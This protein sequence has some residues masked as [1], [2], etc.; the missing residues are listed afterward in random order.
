M[1]QNVCREPI[2][3]ATRASGGSATKQ[4]FLRASGRTS[5][6]GLDPLL[7][8]HWILSLREVSRLDVEIVGKKDFSVARRIK[9]ET[10]ELSFQ[11]S[12]GPRK[13]TKIS[14]CGQQPRVIF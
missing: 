14:K 9:L 5:E 3:G 7:L 11:P 8:R 4:L 10:A 1:G 13:K 2:F 12:P 6:G